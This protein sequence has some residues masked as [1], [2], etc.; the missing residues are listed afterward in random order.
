MSLWYACVNNN[1]DIPFAIHLFTYQKIG[2]NIFHIQYKQYDY[3]CYFVT[4][5]ARQLNKKPFISLISTPE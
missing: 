4:L 1:I 5:Q 2:D 3:W